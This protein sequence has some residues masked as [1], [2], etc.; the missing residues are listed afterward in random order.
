MRLLALPGRAPDLPVAQQIGQNMVLPG[1]FAPD[2]FNAWRTNVGE[3]DPVI[4]AKLKAWT[5]KQPMFFVA[6]APA[7]VNGHVNCSPK[8]RDTLRVVG[9]SEL[10]YLDMGGSG[11]ETVAHLRENQRIV[12]MLCAFEG[13]PRIVRF[14]GRG[15]PVF[16]GDPRF[17]GLLE[18]FP[19]PPA[20]PR[21][22]IRI[23]VTRVADSCGY[24]VPL[25]DYRAERRSIENYVSDKTDADLQA[26]MDEYNEVSIDGLP[27][28]PDRN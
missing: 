25:M 17:A 9:P 6:T 12:I 5:E 26:F 23:D 1:G 11:I 14:H 10:V 13:P 18:K 16:P 20:P 24:G 21:S 2:A 19:P 4:D 15:E 8:G 7:D 27:G 28:L 3:K 22:F